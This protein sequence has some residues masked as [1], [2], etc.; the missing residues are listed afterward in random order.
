MTLN[1]NRA[2]ACL[3]N[4]SGAVFFEVLV[5]IVPMWTL[6]LCSFQLALIAQASLVV[7][8]A[9]D[10]AVRSAI[11]VLPD[12]PHAYAGEPEG[13]VARGSVDSSD[14]DDALRS[15]SEE[16]DRWMAPRFERGSATAAPVAN[17]GGSRLNTIRLAAHVPLMPLSP[18]RPGFDRNPTLGDSLGGRTSLFTSFAYQP[19]A[20][21]VTF[22]G[23]TDDEVEGPEVTVRVS[24]AFQCD[25]PLARMLLC[26]GLELLSPESAF[27]RSFLPASMRF[28]G[29]R[30]KRL[31]HEATLLVQDAPYAYRS[32]TGRP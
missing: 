32:R 19:S 28:G 4:T 31:E 21:A 7:R 15:V 6:F 11:V 8:H 17:L 10:S 26:G 25:V 22:P 18:R 16:A 9:A 24:Y 3:A 13:S 30:F 14:L 23:L 20:V 2:C 12:D 27:A 1:P 29:A 5:V